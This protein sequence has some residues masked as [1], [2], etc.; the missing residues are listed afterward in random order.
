MPAFVAGQGDRQGMSRAQ[1]IFRIEN[2][3][4]S[5]PAGH[6]EA[7]TGAPAIRIIEE[8]R[9]LRALIEP[10][11]AVSQKVIDAFRREMSEA[12]KLKAELDAIHAAIERTKL[13]IATVHQSGF[14]G[15]QMIR[16]TGELDAVVQ[17]TLDATDA[18]LT[19]AET[20]DRDAQTLEA[21]CKTKQD[22]QCAADIQD[23]V[24]KIFEACNFQDLTGQR[25]TKVVGTLAFIEERIVRMM[26][27]W[28]GIETFQDVAVDEPTLPAGDAALINGPRLAT[29]LGH[30]SQDDI[31]ALFG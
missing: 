29:D 2:S 24:I 17:G 10:Q 21:S 4:R 27:I 22:R 28:G 20:I 3:G 8:I 7:A 9:A 26:E 6:G 12:H 1:K 31:D 5:G 15:R 19:A 11:E 13:E 25:I 30:A 23:Q 14:R 18:I 16:V